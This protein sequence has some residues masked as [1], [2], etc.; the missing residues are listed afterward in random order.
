MVINS[1]HPQ[2]LLILSSS[3]ITVCPGWLRFVELNAGV[4]V[5]MA[6]FFEFVCCDVLLHVR[7][8]VRL[9]LYPMLRTIFSLFLQVSRL[10]SLIMLF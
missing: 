5:Y 1:L 7:Q 2:L 8:Q 9:L 4:V 3:M 6:V 10:K